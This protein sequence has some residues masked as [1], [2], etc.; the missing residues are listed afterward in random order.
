MKTDNFL[1][2][3]KTNKLFVRYL[4][5]FILIS[6]I[7]LAITN[8]ICLMLVSKMN[9]NSEQSAISS[10]L[11]ERIK[12]L[13]VYMDTRKRDS[14][15]TSVDPEIISAVADERKGG[16]NR[17]EHIESL[18]RFNITNGCY[19]II[20]FDGRGSAFM[21]VKMGRDTGRPVRES[22]AG[23]AG[24]IHAVQDAIRTGKQQV[25]STE[26]YA[27]AGAFTFYIVDP[28]FENNAVIGAAAFQVNESEME[29]ITSDTNG[30]G[31]TGEIVTGIASDGN[32]VIIAR[33]RNEPAISPGKKLRM[34][35]K[36]GT[37]LL[38]AINGRKGSG[39]ARDYRGVRVLAAWDYIPELKWGIV[40]KKDY[41]EVMAPVK[42]LNAVF[43]FIEFVLLSLI[44]FVA[45]RT[46]MGVTGPILKI[47]SA[48]RR[49]AMGDFTARADVKTGDEIGE[50]AA[51]FNS[52][53][54]RLRMN[55]AEL[56]AVN[57]SLSE[58]EEHFRES[59]EQAAVGIAHSTLDLKF[60]RV[61]KKFCEIMG[62]SR[63]ELMGR[64][65]YDL[66][67]P[68]DRD[69]NM[70]LVVRTRSGEID[71]FSTE[72]RYIKKDG[73]FIWARVW[74]AT[75]KRGGKASEFIAM[76]EDIDSRKKAEEKLKIVMEDLERS[77]ADLE[78]F[79]YISSHD[80][81]EPL[82]SIAGYLQLIELKFRDKLND[83]GRGFIASTIAAAE[84]MRNIINDVLQ[85]SRI[86]GRAV[87]FKEFDLTGAIDQACLNL[88]DV[89]QKSGARVNYGKLP[90][91]FGDLAQ[92]SS[93]F[94]NLIS[95]SIKFKGGE[96]PIIDIGYTAPGQEYVFSLRDNGIGIEPQYF[97][98]IFVIFQR[99]H[100]RN[101]Y[102]GTGIGLA[103]CKKIIERHGGR[104]WVESE[105]GKGSVF[106]FSLPKGRKNGHWS[107][108][109]NNTSG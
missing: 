17:A 6:I 34:D 98:K 30:L 46:S 58:S 26:F 63:E 77:N 85:Y 50:L 107:E 42:N 81:Q 62:Y 10:T 28:V 13:N 61:N 4:L 16:I 74:V 86:G 71:S 37:S 5:I 76:V 79:A 90:A 47:A 25:S 39:S 108:A 104:I 51:D 35:S 66:T 95:N 43:L 75:V 78:Q 56:N 24:L 11:A 40:V 7:P 44:V 15:D 89:I 93:V 48:A 19:D 91:V 109:G 54:D 96:M 49:T 68:D 82:R 102:P 55:M 97:D 72:K 57:A 84:R 52:M 59:F 14:V 80:L 33:L 41:K 60:F 27:A 103:V 31:S 53:T 92:L 23:D 36:N 88:E 69:M 106:Y 2:A 22:A 20:L 64:S 65:F 105:P 70:G 29:A 73:S 94:Q 101:E 21:A 45:Y 83:E 99:L 1:S 67:H 9:L 32:A 12:F 8:I 100:A 18:K 3:L 38:S 87:H